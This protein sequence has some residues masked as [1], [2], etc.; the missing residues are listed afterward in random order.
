MT[1]IGQIWPIGLGLKIGW[2]SKAVS[3]SSIHLN[4]SDIAPSEHCCLRVKDRNLVLARQGWLVF[5]SSRVENHE[6]VQNF[7]VPFV[8]SGKVHSLIWLLFPNK[9]YKRGLSEP[10]S[11]Q[12]SIDRPAITLIISPR[13]TNCWSEEIRNLFDSSY[14]EE[15]VIVSAG[16]NKNL[17]WQ[18]LRWPRVRSSVKNDLQMDKMSMGNTTCTFIRTLEMR[19]SPSFCGRT[20]CMFMVIWHRSLLGETFKNLAQE[21]VNANPGGL[22]SWIVTCELNMGALI[23]RSVSLWSLTIGRRILVITLFRHMR[24]QYISEGRDCEWRSAKNITECW[25]G[26]VEPL[27]DGVGWQRH[28]IESMACFIDQTFT[29]LQNTILYVKSILKKLLS[30]RLQCL[31]WQ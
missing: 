20:Y 13:T 27:C 8:N 14:R 24:S 25:R 30:Q 28:L 16:G 1:Q 4:F 3:T 23:E 9:L 18:Q 19:Q 11:N 10:I 22:L 6:S 17:I 5:Q 2:I 7:R 29:G 15:A 26:Q 12:D 21:A 31:F